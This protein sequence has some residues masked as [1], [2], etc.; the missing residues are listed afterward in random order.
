MAEDKKDSLELAGAPAKSDGSDVDREKRYQQFRQMMFAAANQLQ[1][2]NLFKTVTPT[3]TQ[4]TKENYRNYIQNPSR[5]EKDIRAMS[6]FLTRVSMPY[7]RLLWYFATMYSFY[8]N[9]MPKIDP[10]DLPDE[11][12]LMAAYGEMCQNIDKL[13]MPLEMT[14]ILYFMLRD[15]IFYGFLYEDDESIFI[16]RL[17]PDYCRPVQLEAGV[18]NFAFDYSYF[19]KYPE[20]LQTW[21]SSF[22]TGYN[23]Y[24]K[25]NTNMRWQI[26]DP[27][28]T[29][30]IKADPDLDEILPFFVGIF[31]ALL[32]LI[33]ARTLQRNKD[34]IQNYKLITQKI[35]F[36]NDDAAKTTD[37]FKL[38]IDTVMKFANQL[39]DS[40]PEAVGVATTPMEIDTIDFKTDDNSSDLNSSSMRQ[41]FDD[42]G[43]SQ[44][45]FNSSTSGSTGVDSSVKT[46]AALA[47]QWVKQIER[48]VK[49]F[50]NYRKGNTSF[51]FE[52]LDVHIWNKDSAVDRELKLA[53]SGVP[54]KMKLAATAG[55]SPSEVMSAQIWENQYLK[56]HENWKPL[57]TS[58][59][60]SA[61]AGRPSNEE[62]GNVNDSTSKNKDSGEDAGNSIEE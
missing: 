24:D 5:N 9:L 7:R 18:L 59:T 57:Q 1:F 30:C 34:V 6:Q 13:E 31:E 62:T 42:S 29:I 50:I 20:A 36:F 58:Y 19:K 44:L 54:N 37:D 33:D 11:D 26:L 51:D 41:I 2:G 8:W 32:D 45:L 39:A 21:D 55:M 4:Y 15:G 61:E 48:W 23:A 60:M 16:H 40:V 28:R 52:I 35:P 47:Y 17:N 10:A 3:Y 49:R 56:I 12:D 25:D 27:E 14:N 22:Q 46:D 43:V 38:E 53:N